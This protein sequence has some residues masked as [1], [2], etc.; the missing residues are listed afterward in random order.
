MGAMLSKAES[1][2]VIPSIRRLH[3]PELRAVARHF[4]DVD[5]QLWRYRLPLVGDFLL[6][7]RIRR[8]FHARGPR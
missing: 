2:Y 8:V 5:G 3:G 1:K 7:R 4:F 6:R